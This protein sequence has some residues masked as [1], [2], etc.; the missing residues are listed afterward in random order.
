MLS[1]KLFLLVFCLF[2]SKGNIETLCFSIEAKQ[3]KQTE[4]KQNK[5]KRPKIFLKNTKICSFVLL[6]CLFQFNQNTQT[7]CFGTWVQNETTE[8]NILFRLVPKLVSVPVLVVFNVS[9]D[10]LFWTLFEVEE[11]LYRWSNYGLLTL[12]LFLTG[13]SLLYIMDESTEQLTVVSCYRTG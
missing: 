8:T 4:T 9:K 10:T 7:L 1:I 6:F 3:P 2:R 12:I 11:L 5:S 13:Q